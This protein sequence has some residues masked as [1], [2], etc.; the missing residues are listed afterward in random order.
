ME[1]PLF[2]N[3]KYVK[4]GISKYV[5]WNPALAPHFVAFGTTGSG[6][7]YGM[8]LVLAK[9][10]KY[11]SDSQ[12]FVADYKG[13]FDFSFLE[14]SNRFYRFMECEK[15]LDEVYQILRK[16]QAGEDKTRNMIIL[17]F[18]EWSSYILS[19]DKKK[20]DE[21][22]QKL[23]TLLMLSRSFNIHI[24]LSQ[25]RVDSQY[26]GSSR[27]CFNCVLALSNLSKEGKE[28]MFHEYKDMMK[29]DRQ[30]GTGYML[31]NGMDFVPVIVPTIS[32]MNL[33]HQYIK[34]AVNR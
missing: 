27:D 31:I 16:R 14:G 17:Y 10:S 25:Q 30:R 33:V 5:C 26:F 34:D 4:C 15:A 28:M 2:L 8:K 3:E 19:L 22:K 6:K 12:L 11:E 32:D 13:D 18:D 21:D 9:I 1:I 23:S 24:F 20:A 7:T 29:P